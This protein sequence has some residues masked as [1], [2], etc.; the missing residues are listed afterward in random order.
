MPIVRPATS[1][2]RHFVPIAG[3]L[4]DIEKAHEH[5]LEQGATPVGVREVVADSWLRSVAAGVDVD[6]SR[7]P[8]TLDRDLLG[9]YRAG[10]PLATVFPMLY[11]VLG[12]AAE[13]CDSVVAIADARGQLLWVRGPSQVRRRAESIQFVEGAQWDERHAGTNAPGTALR[14]DA[15]VAI[16]SA[17]HFVRPVQRWSCA[18]APMHAPGTDTILGVI[19]ITGGRH[20]DAPQTIAMVRAAARMAE[21]EL[22]RH[23]LIAVSQYPESGEVAGPSRWTA[24]ISLSG[25]GRSECVVSIGPRTVR[26][27]PRHSEIMVILAACPCGLTGDELAYMLYPADVISSTP[28]AELVRLRALLGDRV[29]ASRP[30]RLTC[31]VSSDWAAVSAQLAAGDLAEA[32]RLYRGPLLPRSEAPGVAEIREDL[33]RALR[34][35]VLAAAAPEFLV[36]WTRTRWGADDLEIWQRLCAV[37]PAASPLRPIAAATAARLDAELGR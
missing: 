24:G 9:E 20:V 19:D 6:A 26:L 22:A 16:K 25:L 8:I 27:S 10:H 34:A 35:A 23:A 13:D 31:E 21:S 32:L 14:L 33:H 28:R 15:P 36:S 12:P 1:C 5:L 29:L 7:P 2:Y 17:E 37:L 11:D 4:P 3:R 18:A 30:Y